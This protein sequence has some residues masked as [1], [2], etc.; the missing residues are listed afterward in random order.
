M[1]I[2]LLIQATGPQMEVKS[3]S[4]RVPQNISQSVW[5]TMLLGVVF[6]ALRYCP[7]NRIYFLNLVEF[8]QICYILHGFDE[9]RRNL[10]LK[11]N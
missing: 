10:N 1:V 7:P 6:G 9:I 3:I 4:S 8:M 2:L 11:P 5:G